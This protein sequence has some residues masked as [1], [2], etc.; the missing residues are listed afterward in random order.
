MHDGQW[1]DVVVECR[2]EVMM[3]VCRKESSSRN[4]L[5]KNVG[6]IKKMS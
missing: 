5:M 2:H 4:V 1:H 6:E 3:N